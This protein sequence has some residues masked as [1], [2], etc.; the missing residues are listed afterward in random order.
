M[1]NIES[2]IRCYE[3][4]NKLQNFGNIEGCRDGAF[5]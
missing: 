2:R 3:K 4:K 5:F 1:K